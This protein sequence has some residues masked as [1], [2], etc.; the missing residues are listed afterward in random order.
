MSKPLS[1][2]FL[3]SRKKCCQNGCQNCP[4]KTMYVPLPFNF[5]L[6][7]PTHKEG[8]EDTKKLIKNMEEK[9]KYY[10]PDREDFREGFEYE[11]LHCSYSPPDFKLTSSDWVLVCDVDEL[12]DIN[13]SLL[14]TDQTLFKSKG[15][16]MCNVEG[17]DNVLD[18]KH[19]IEAVQYDKVVCFNKLYIKEIN[20]TPGC[21]SCNPIG[22]VIYGQKIRP[23]LL[24]M[25]FINEDLLAEKYKSYKSRLSAENL[26]NN[27]GFQYKEE[28]EKVRESYKNHLKISKNI[29]GS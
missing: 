22:D 23:I 24:H 26:K 1:R 3:L 19:G 14:N 29:Y 25:K 10:I 17:L 2:E 15:Y 18:I 4:Y 20:Y 28:E 11:Q 8:L 7:I 9:E 6:K 5:N 27:W 21:H 12:L 13:S 16:N